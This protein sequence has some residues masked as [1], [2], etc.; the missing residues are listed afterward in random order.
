M[1]TALGFICFMSLL[2]ACA[3][4]ETF[5]AQLAWTLSMLTVCVISGKILANKYMTKKELEEEV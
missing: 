3:E 1:K 5:T 2:L 4:A